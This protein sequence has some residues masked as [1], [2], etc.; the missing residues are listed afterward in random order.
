MTVALAQF[1]RNSRRS[2][3]QMLRQEWYGFSMAVLLALVILGPMFNVF[4]WAFTQR[5]RYPALLP[6]EWGIRFWADTFAAPISPRV[7]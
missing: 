7:S 6:T 1:F 4:L 2:Y 3:A 5:W